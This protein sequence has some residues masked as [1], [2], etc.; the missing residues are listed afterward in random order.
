MD[1]QDEGMRAYH[2]RGSFGEVEARSK[3]SSGQ[4]RSQEGLG[5]VTQ[6]QSWSFQTLSSGNLFVKYTATEILYNKINSEYKT[7]F[8][9]LRTRSMIHQQV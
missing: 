7:P 9:N 5:K 2:V 4:P 3:E 8:L 1:R 6:S